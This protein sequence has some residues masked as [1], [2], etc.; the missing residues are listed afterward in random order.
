MFISARILI[1]AFLTITIT[2]SCSADSGKPGNSSEIHNLWQ[3][4][5]L[6]KILPF[7]IFNDAMTGYHHTDYRRK[8]NILTIIDFS[9]PSTDERF[10]VIDLDSRKL[11]FHCLVAHG[12]NSGDN[13]AE[14]FSNENGSLKSSLGFYLTA[15]TYTGTHGYTLCLDG[16]EK[17]INDNARSREIVIHGAEYVSQEFIAKYGRLGK[18]WGCPA[19]PTQISKEVIDRISNG[20]CLFIYGKDVNYTKNSKFLKVKN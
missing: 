4:C 2:V 12:K 18:S 11:L 15:E 9:K 6:E 20:S 13:F 8:K 19:L 3:E 5:G 1:A 16:L 7:D 17:D 14:S 10:F